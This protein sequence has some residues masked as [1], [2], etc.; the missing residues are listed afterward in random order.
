MLGWYNN[1]NVINYV[2]IH[3]ASF[4]V[5]HFCNIAHS[6][7]VPLL[8]NLIER[9]V[10][11]IV[12]DLCQIDLYPDLF[13]TLDSDCSLCL[14]LIHDSR[15]TILESWVLLEFVKNLNLNWFRKQNTRKTKD[16]CRLVT[17]CL[18]AFIHAER[19][20]ADSQAR[21]STRCYINVIN[22]L[23]T[24]SRPDLRAK[25]LASAEAGDPALTQ[26]SRRSI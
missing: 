25:P 5:L 13:L 6:Y 19:I 10:M 18:A 3:F 2:C 14:V 16:I 21:E 7:R 8:F 15:F 22:M 1:D 11:Y 12:F 9:Q 4:G 23:P 26:R 17:I 20:K 24:S